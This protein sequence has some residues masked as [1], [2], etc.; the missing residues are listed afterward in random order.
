MTLSRRYNT[1]TQAL[2]WLGSEPAHSGR[3]ESTYHART[4]AAAV[5]PL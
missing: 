4:A 5:Q 3:A 1:E 2:Q